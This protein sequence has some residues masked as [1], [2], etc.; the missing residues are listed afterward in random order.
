MSRITPRKPGESPI[1]SEVDFN[2]PDTRCASTAMATVLVI[3]TVREIQNGH[4]SLASR[5]SIDAK[6]SRR[7]IKVQSRLGA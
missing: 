6:T 2:A 7:V 4:A 5:G 3:G 1:V